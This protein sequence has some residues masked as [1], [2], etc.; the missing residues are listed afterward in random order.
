MCSF[1]VEYDRALQETSCIIFVQLLD[2]LESKMEGT[3]MERII[4]SLFKGQYV[5]S[6]VSMKMMLTKRK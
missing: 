1:S 2:R 6:R 3:T 5:V 4:P